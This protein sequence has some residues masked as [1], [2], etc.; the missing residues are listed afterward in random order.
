VSKD[1]ADIA[2]SMRAAFVT[3]NRRL[4]LTLNQ[5]L[6]VPVRLR[7]SPNNDIGLIG[8][9]LPLLLPRRDEAIRQTTEIVII[10]QVWQRSRRRRALSVSCQIWYDEASHSV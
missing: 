1:C 2:I 9:G 8:K 4:D 7:S 3:A 5:G 6:S 10:V